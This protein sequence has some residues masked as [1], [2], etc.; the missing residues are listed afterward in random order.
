MSRARLLPVICESRGL[1]ARVLLMFLVAFP[2][3]YC[4]YAILRMTRIAD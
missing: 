1:L 3:G 4:A 2:T